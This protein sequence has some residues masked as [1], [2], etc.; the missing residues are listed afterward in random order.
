MDEFSSSAPTTSS[1][2]A[3]LRRCSTRCIPTARKVIRSSAWTSARSTAGGCGRSIV[4]APRR[5]RMGGWRLPRVRASRWAGP[6]V[7]HRSCDIW[8]WKPATW[9][10]CRMGG[11]SAPCRD[12]FRSRRRCGRRS[13]SCR[14][15]ALKRSPWSIRTA[16]A[17]KWWWCSSRRV[18]RSTR[19]SISGRGRGR[20]CWRRR[21]TGARRMTWARPAFSSARTRGSRRTPRRAGRTCGPSACSPAKD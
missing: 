15:T 19:R 13:A 3:R 10:R 4:A 12:D 2:A 8:A 20:R 9:R 1:T 6:A 7:R 16:A 5:C 18:S 11:C 14:T 21:L 17:T